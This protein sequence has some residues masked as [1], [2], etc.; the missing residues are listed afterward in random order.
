M[1][2]ARCHDRGFGT[3]PTAAPLSA[4]SVLHSCER[5][6][7]RKVARSRPAPFG[8]LRGGAEGPGQ[9]WSTR[10]PLGR[11]RKILRQSSGSTFTIEALWLPPTQKVTGVV[12]LSTHTRRTLV[13]RGS[14]YSTACP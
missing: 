2:A 8:R 6:A 11:V 12:E 1:F 5:G 9:L 13:L 10:H 14:W 7:G 4:T 3:G